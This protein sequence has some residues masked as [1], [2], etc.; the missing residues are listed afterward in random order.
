MRLLIVSDSHGDSHIL[1]QLVDRYQDKVDKFVH[2]GDSELSDRDLVWGVMDTVGG[3]CDF[4]GDFNLSHVERSL[5]FPYGIVHGHHHDVKWSLDKLKAF[6]ESEALRFV[7]YGHSHILAADY[8]DGVF[9]INPGSI[10]SP[11]GSVYEKTY[12]LLDATEE[13]VELKVY[14]DK[15]KEIPSLGKKWTQTEL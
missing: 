2:C 4:Y 8:E 5:E 13:A 15:H 14:N 6:A 3:N 11:R 1:N 12:C 7:F 9:F 10:K